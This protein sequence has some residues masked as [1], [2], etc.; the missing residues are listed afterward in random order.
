M[1]RLQQTLFWNVD[2]ATGS[3]QE[4]CYWTFKKVVR[5][6]EYSEL[7]DFKNLSVLLAQILNLI[8]KRFAN[9][10]LLVR[11]LF[12]CCIEMNMFLSLQLNDTLISYV[13]H[14]SSLFKDNFCVVKCSFFFNN[15][16]F[17]RSSSFL[18]D[19][20]NFKV[21]TLYFTFQTKKSIVKHKEELS[22]IC[23]D[24]HISSDQI[25]FSQWK[26]EIQQ[27]A[28]GKLIFFT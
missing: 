9:K 26:N 8:Q 25:D 5:S 6:S 14:I 18:V 12:I 17:Q 4:D 13:D 2:N 11:L 21:V 16:S 15:L 7:H 22:K 27:I 10:Q 19:M 1:E 20:W 24:S 28:L 3:K 23:E